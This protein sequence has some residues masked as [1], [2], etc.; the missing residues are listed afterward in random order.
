MHL[1]K[2][3][4]LLYILYGLGILLS[5]Y[6]FE[7]S[8]DLNSHQSIL[9]FSQNIGNAF[10]GIGQS[11]SG[12]MIYAL[13]LM[14]SNVAFFTILK[15]VLRYSFSDLLYFISATLSLSFLLFFISTANEYFNAYCTAAIPLIIATF[16]V[17]FNAK[18]F[19]IEAAEYSTDDTTGDATKY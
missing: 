15:F 4:L 9:S 8:T 19:S 18:V 5:D 13:K 3:I 14:I 2:T 10:Y 17:S 7:N 12:S 1:R 6:Y 11:L 16:Y